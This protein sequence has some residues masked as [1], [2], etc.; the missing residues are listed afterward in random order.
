VTAKMRKPGGFLL[1]DLIVGISL[2]AMLLAGLGISVAGFSG[3]NRYQWTRQQCTAA[4]IAQLDSLTATGAPIDS[5]DAG[6]LWPRVTVSLDR[7]PG[8][9]PWAGLERINVKASA[10]AGSRKVTVELARYVTPAVQP[11][12]QEGSL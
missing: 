4:A 7:T 8:E 9:G 2:F 3:F 11:V 1:A 10:Q 12:K 5:E 6:R